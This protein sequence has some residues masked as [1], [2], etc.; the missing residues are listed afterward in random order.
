M[1]TILS[2]NR[3]P[4]SLLPLIIG[5]ICFLAPTQK[6]SAYVATLDQQILSFA[7]DTASNIYHAI[8]DALDYIEKVAQTLHLVEIMGFTDKINEFTDNINRVT[9]AIE[10]FTAIPGDL[11]EAVTSAIG[12]TIGSVVGAITSPISGVSG[13]FQDIMGNVNGIFQNIGEIQAIGGQVQDIA[14]VFTEAGVNDAYG[15]FGKVQGIRSAFS[16]AYLDPEMAEARYEPLQRIV[17][18]AGSADTIAKQSR[19]QAALQAFSIREQATA[20]QQ[21]ALQSQYEVA[22]SMAAEQRSM[23]NAAIRNQRK[24]SY[25]NNLLD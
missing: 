4:K 18:E 19:S 24:Q 11:F 23:A 2:F 6:A 10:D 17:E 13:A 20:N 21:M 14:S 25:I 1:S 15:F 3:L 12:D 5:A 7:E 22:Q 9:G 16:G 8:D